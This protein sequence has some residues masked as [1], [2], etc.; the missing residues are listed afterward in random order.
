[1]IACSTVVEQSFLKDGSSVIAEDFIVL[2]K[3]MLCHWVSIPDTVHDKH[4]KSRI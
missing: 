4:S 2:W 3:V 1:M